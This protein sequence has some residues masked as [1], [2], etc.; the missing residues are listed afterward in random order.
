MHSNN[1]CSFRQVWRRGWPLV[2]L[3]ALLL[4][5]LSL[6][7]A[8]KPPSPLSQPAWERVERL[9]NKQV[10]AYQGWKVGYSLLHLPSQKE[11]ARQGEELFPLASVYKLPLLLAVCQKFQEEGRPLTVLQ[12]KVALKPGDLCPGSGQFQD[13]PLGTKVS[14]DSALRAIITDSD[15]TASD[16]LVRY[17]GS[18]NL[19]SA[20]PSWGLPTSQ[21]FLSSRQ[22]WLLSLGAH[23]QLGGGD[24]LRAAQIW[25]SLT[26]EQ[27]QKLAS[28]VEREQASLSLAQFK[29]R[30]QKT[31]EKYPFSH[32]VAASQ[33]DNLG[34]PSEF[35]RILGLLHSGRILKGPWRTYALTR[36]AQ[37]DR[38]QRLARFIPASNPFYHK[39]GSNQGVVNDCALFPSRSGQPLALAVFIYGISP[40]EREEASLALSQMAYTAWYEL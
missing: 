31:K 5:P 17:L 4:C 9:L 20:L 21:V 34:T 26:Y 14:L 13:K 10:E 37:T 8:P 16:L 3:I 18:N 22:S 35:S 28:E 30:D 11:I 27:R 29:A 12:E 40:Q 32:F 38:T 7:S 6:L 1:F 36:L 39:T 15:N 25:R 33:V 19:R 24:P 23:P 2:C